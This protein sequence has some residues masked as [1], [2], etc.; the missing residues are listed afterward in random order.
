MF[1]FRTPISDGAGESLLNKPKMESASP[2]E[3]D[4]TS[5]MRDSQAPS[6][7]IMPPAS[8]T[9]VAA[10][11]NAMRY[12]RDNRTFDRPPEEYHFEKAKWLSEIADELKK[13]NME[14][15]S[16]PFIDPHQ[17]LKDYGGL[18]GGQMNSMIQRELLKLRSEPEL[19]NPDWFPASSQ[20]LADDL[21]TTQFVSGAPPTWIASMPLFGDIDRDTIMIQKTQLHDLRLNYMLD[22]IILQ[23]EERFFSSLLEG[24]PLGTPIVEQIQTS[25]PTDFLNEVDFSGMSA[26]ELKRVQ[27]EIEELRRQYLLGIGNTVYA[28]ELPIFTN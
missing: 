23:E 13:S 28:M 2:H 22:L 5:V 21:L 14:F 12:L 16:Y 3:V 11:I 9:E 18:I 27:L 1:F 17:T 24:H 25:G 26:I 10:V 8:E 19:V 7:P 15:E 20:E 4:P 6:R